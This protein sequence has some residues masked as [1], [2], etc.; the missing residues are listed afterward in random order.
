MMRRH[1]AAL[2]LWLLLAPVLVGQEKIAAYSEQLWKDYDFRELVPREKFLEFC[3]LLKRL[4][5]QTAEKQLD[6]FVRQASVDDDHAGWVLFL[7]E[8]YIYHPESRFH[9]ERLFRSGIK[10]MTACMALSDAFRAARQYQWESLSRCMEGE[11]AA[12][13]RVSL[14]TGQSVLVSDVLSPYLLLLFYNPNCERCHRLMEQIRN[15]KIIDSLIQGE[16]LR[17]L[18]VYP[19]IP[20]D[21]ENWQ[22]SD[23]PSG[24]INGYDCEQA[25]YLHRLYTLREIPATYLLNAAGTLLLKEA[26][27]DDLERFFG[28][29]FPDLSAT[30]PDCSGQD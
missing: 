25:V 22:L 10:V 21:V 14:S 2:F 27:F 20:E 17:I 4:P 30:A 1:V 15:S 6:I 12:D 3:F 28:S 24:W 29:L 19:L 26:S 11:Q 13:F 16:N 7:M 5:E 18:A 9:N 23:L 8:S